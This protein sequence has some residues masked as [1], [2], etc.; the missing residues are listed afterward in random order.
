MS[1][2]TGGS[3]RSSTADWSSSADR[4][5]GI[6]A[7]TDGLRVDVEGAVATL[8]LDRPEAL[9]ALTVP[10]KVALRE[11]L[12]S[13]NDDRDVRAVILTGAGRASAPA[14]TSPSARRLTRRR[15]MSSSVSATT[16]SS[17]PSGR[18]ASP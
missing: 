16:R 8:T 12:E 9:N 6:R 7:V 15:S 14:R 10:V 1:R 11:A 2:S 4:P 17:A 5:C 13:L 18:W 3:L